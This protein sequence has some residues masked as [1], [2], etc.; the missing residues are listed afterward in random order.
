MKKTNG[1]QKPRSDQ[2]YY[3]DSSAPDKAVV[4]DNSKEELYTV[5]W[6]INDM[7]NVIGEYFR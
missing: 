1:M 5:K 7:L 6:Q 3:V 4:I 2:V